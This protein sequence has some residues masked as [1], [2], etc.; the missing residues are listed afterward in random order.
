MTTS[1][2]PLRRQHFARLREFRR[3][4]DGGRGLGQTLNSPVDGY[5]AANGFLQPGKYRGGWIPSVKGLEALE[6]REK[7]E[8][9]GRQPHNDL[10]RR[11][12]CWL[13]RQGRLAWLNR[14]FEVSTRNDLR[15]VKHLQLLSSLDEP[16]DYFSGPLCYTAR[17]DVI[18]IL[19]SQR[20]AEHEPWIFEVKVS[21]RDFYVDVDKPEKRLA[22]ALLAE[23]VYYVCPQG[24]LSVDEVPPG[25]GFVVEKRAGVF[26]V[27]VEAPR[28]KVRHSAH[29]NRLLR[30]G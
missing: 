17:P 15:A 12:G 8:A 2:E 27:L 24:L 6:A 23:R 4:S 19:P 30:R 7:L 5:L 11:V 1:D 22:Y 10:A 18:S 26:E 3:Y 21:R 13:E 9:R 29:I 28:C 25:C 16:D 14:S 20:R